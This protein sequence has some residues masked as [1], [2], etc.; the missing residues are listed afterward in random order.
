VVIARELTKMFEE[1]LRGPVSEL[2][3]ALRQ[4]AGGEGVQGEV[5]LLVAG[6]EKG[7]STLSPDELEAEIKRRR[8]AGASLKEVAR[9]LADEYGLSRREVYQ[10]GLKVD[11]DR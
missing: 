6:A 5:T 9:Q 10:V 4:R 1:V 11:G 7:T 8:G 3:V 2:L